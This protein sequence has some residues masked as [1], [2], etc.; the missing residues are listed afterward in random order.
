[1]EQTLV[2]QQLRHREQQ[3]RQREADLLNREVPLPITSPT[4]LP[5]PSP[6]EVPLPITSPTSLPLPL[7]FLFVD[8]SPL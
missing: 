8:N 4:S 6:R 3:L 1:M 7:S 2:Q 5:L